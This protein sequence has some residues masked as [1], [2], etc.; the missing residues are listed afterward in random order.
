VYP[1]DPDVEKNAVLQTKDSIQQLAT[2]AKSLHRLVVK[3]KPD[4][5]ACQGFLLSCNIELPYGHVAPMA[6]PRKYSD[7]PDS[8]PN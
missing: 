1:E 7:I 8:H 6:R 2:N 3:V 5:G 4:R